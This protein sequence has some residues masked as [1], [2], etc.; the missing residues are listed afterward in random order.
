MKICRGCGELWEK[1][2]LLYDGG[3]DTFVCPFCG[4]EVW[5]EYDEGW[6]TYNATQR[7]REERDDWR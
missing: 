7:E 1:S 5:E 4:D 2:E 3:A 6:E